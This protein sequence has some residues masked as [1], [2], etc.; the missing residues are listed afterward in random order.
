LAHKKGEKKIIENIAGHI[1]SL[2]V[3]DSIMKSNRMKIGDEKRMLEFL[4]A[5]ESLLCNTP[6]PTSNNQMVMPP[7][8]PVGAGNQ[9]FTA[10]QILAR[11]SKN[12]QIQ[13]FLGSSEQ[14][15]RE[16]IPDIST[17]TDIQGIPHHQ[18][19]SISN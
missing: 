14:D 13:P 7:R 3:L 9:V 10:N 18:S 12:G 19:N 8:T 1:S 5:V 15:H 16:A 6:T 11:N 4:S 2:P 17:F